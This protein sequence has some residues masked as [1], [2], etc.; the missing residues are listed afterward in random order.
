MARFDWHD[1]QASA[2]EAV[3]V[4]GPGDKVF[5]GTACATPRSL[6]QALEELNRS[7]VTLV[8]FLTDRFG[9]DDPPQTNYRH[10]VF[11][12][13]RDMRA[14]H[15]PMRQVEYLPLSVAD[16]PRSSSASANT[17]TNRRNVSSE[18]LMPASSPSDARAVLILLARLTRCGA[19][20][21]SRPAERC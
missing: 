21:P 1:R 18:V 11:Y 14:L 2:A 3:S 9:T 20:L 15:G 19:E 7:G 5:I 13:G 12:V 17:S 8:H 4:V 6:L 16:V 10:R